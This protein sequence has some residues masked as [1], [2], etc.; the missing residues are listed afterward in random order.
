MTLTQPLSP[1]TTA[2]YATAYHAYIAQPEQRNL[3]QS[4]RTAIEPMFDWVAKMLG[5]TGRQKQLPVQGLDNVRTCLALAL[6]TLTVQVAMIAKSIWG[7]P[8]RNISTIAMALT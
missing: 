8:L 6:A 7:L 5:T 3:L 2:S 4:R 1:R